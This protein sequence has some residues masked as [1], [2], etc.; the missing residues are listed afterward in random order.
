MHF[1]SAGIKQFPF[2]VSMAAIVRF[3][4]KGKNEKGR[5]RMLVIKRIM[6]E[7]LKSK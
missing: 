5:E 1:V 4:N 6:P 7:E 3:E 2:P